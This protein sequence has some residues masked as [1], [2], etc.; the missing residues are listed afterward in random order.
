MILGF[1][2]KMFIICAQ[3]GIIIDLTNLK[4]MWTNGENGKSQYLG[5]INFWKTTEE[6]ILIYIYE[7]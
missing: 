2:D 6:F 3:I 1:S 4:K 7:S 5:A